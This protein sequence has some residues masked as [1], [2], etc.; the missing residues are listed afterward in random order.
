MIALIYS[1]K[2]WPLLLGKTVGAPTLQDVSG[3]E[4]MDL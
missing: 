2:V 3:A 1:A 4:G